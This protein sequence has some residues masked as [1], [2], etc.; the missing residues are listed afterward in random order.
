MSVVYYYFRSSYNTP[1]HGLVKCTSSKPSEKVF[2]HLRVSMTIFSSS[3]ESGQASGGESTA[4][5]EVKNAYF[6][7]ARTIHTYTLARAVVLD[8]L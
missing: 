8:Q 5:L 1:Q 3:G 6:Q 4:Q 7:N 2:Y